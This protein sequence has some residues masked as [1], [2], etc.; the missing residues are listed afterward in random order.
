MS[1]PYSGAALR[2]SARTF[3][4]GKVISALLTFAILLWL[5]RLL[6]VSE[7][8][9]YV[10]FI[11]CTEL[12]FAIADLGLAWLAARYLPDYRL[13]AS[14][15]QLFLLCLKIFACQ[16]FSLLFFAFIFYTFLTPYLNWLELVQFK[17]VALLFL[18]VLVIEGLARSMQEAL[19]GPLMLQGGIRLS[20]IGRQC[21]YL[22]CLSFI[23][24]N[25]VST[26]PYNLTQIAIV[27]LLASVMGMVI[28]I[29]CLLLFFR[30]HQQATSK[31][32]QGQP[33]AK[34]WA[35]AWQM[36]IAHILT[37]IYSPQVLIN[38][39]QRVLGAEATALFG[40]LRILNSQISRYLPATLM[41]SLI[42]PKLV[43]TF[44]S[45]GGVGG[46]SQMTNMVGKFSLWV[47]LPL[48][49]IAAIA[50]DPIVLMAS[51]GKFANSGY[52]LL[53]FFLL[54]VPFSQRQLLETVAVTL[55]KASLCKWASVTGILTLPLMW[56]LLQIGF[57]LWSAIIAIGLG[58]ILFNLCL[59]VGLGRSSGYKVDWLGYGK[60]VLALIIAL[61]VGWLINQWSIPKASVTLTSGII[62]IAIRSL[63]VAFTFVFSSWLLNPFTSQEK[64]RMSA[65]VK[66]RLFFL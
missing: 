20:V 23:V 26:D 45:G 41:F 33:M 42:R 17:T 5:V 48:V 66:R 52:L 16:A 19:L 56:L 37:L 34:Q 28:A 38:L 18:G 63:V 1:Q 51:G 31:D 4:T 12:G 58:Y 13:N 27:E 29:A 7:Y 60:L 57:V 55:N 32:W 35:V 2:S 8:G 24:F 21:T 49:T 15:H 50:G 62:D 40:F 14:S 65:F 61:I 22:L 59:V 30:N 53:G 44:V 25:D 9:V 36:Y 10:T 46:L 3:L 43:A 6:P 47:L 64:L 11:A 54:L 39:L